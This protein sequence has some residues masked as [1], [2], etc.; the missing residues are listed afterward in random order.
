[1]IV[2]RRLVRLPSGRHM[3]Y[4]RAGEG[5]P[6]VLLHPAMADGGFFAADMARWAEGHTVL[7]FDNA[8][9]G[10]S[11]PLDGTADVGGLAEALAEALM[12]L[13]M[14]PAVLFGYHSGAAVAVEAAARHPQLVAG[15]VIDGMPI[16]TRPETDAL[17]AGDFAPPLTIDPLGGHFSATWTRFRD[18]AAF[19]PWHAK[20]PATILPLAR[21]AT[22]D[23]V[24]RWV[25]YFYRS[26]ES[27][28][29]P[30]RD[31]HDYGRIAAGRIAALGVPA[32]FVMAEG[33]FLTA[34]AERLP[35]GHRTIRTTAAD[36]PAL[37]AD[38]FAELA[39][40]VSASHDPD[41]PASGIARHYVDLPTGQM[42]VR[43][44]GESDA[45]PLLLL[46]DA[47]GSSEDIAAR[48]TTLAR[49]FRV[50]A[51]DL[52]GCGGSDP[53]PGIPTIMD[54]AAAVESVLGA[55][56]I[57]R[58]AVHG[59]GFG[60]SVACAV[61]TASSIVLEGLLLPDDGARADMAE[62]YVPAIPITEDGAHWY[63]TWLMLRDAE[64]WFPWYDRRAETQRDIVGDFDGRT[65]HRRTL[66]LRNDH[67]GYGQVVRA[68]LA[69]DA[70]AALSARTVPIRQICN[71]A[72]PLSAYDD[73]LAALLAGSANP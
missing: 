37:L 35:E 9:F 44:A 26:A 22:A 71:P 65:L 29:A 57:E 34:H 3:H 19:Y 48:I 56:R 5:R 67:E 18:Q 73:R 72:V 62:R 69:H 20:G 4:R 25:R 40:P 43:S 51:P 66:A 24:D 23:H 13:A 47:P 38:L 60:S 31:V 16:F 42:L 28:S 36:K 49:D 1:M 46:H 55:C 53:L 8:G 21:P 15:L 63:R 61:S 32:R 33:D 12:A 10:L 70:S 39:G 6:L 45:P 27:Y 11:D 59:I 52:P 54:I 2:R 50:I 7:A 30:F 68:A 14:P 17:F 58:P 41:P 64:I